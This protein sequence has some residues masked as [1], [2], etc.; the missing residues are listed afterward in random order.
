[1]NQNSF[2]KGNSVEVVKI[3]ILSLVIGFVAERQQL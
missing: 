1:M 2:M 3:L